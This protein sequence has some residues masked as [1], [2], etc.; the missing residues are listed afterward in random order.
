MILIATEIGRGW[1]VEFGMVEQV[2]GNPLHPYTQILKKSIPEPDPTKKWSEK[3]VLARAETEE[4]LQAGC[5]FAVRCPRV[6][7]ICKTVV[8]PAVIFKGRSVKCNLYS[9]PKP[10]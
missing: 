6:M 9:D 4:F 10:A 3:I 5:K 8:P 1:V 7:D 2:L